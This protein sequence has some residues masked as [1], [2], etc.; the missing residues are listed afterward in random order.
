MIQ[1]SRLCQRQATRLPPPG[2]TGR[3]RSRWPPIDPCGLSIEPMPAVCGLLTITFR[4]NGHR[5]WF[6]AN[7]ETNY[8]STQGPTR[9]R[10]SA[11]VHERVRRAVSTGRRAAGDPVIVRS[12]TSKQAVG[13]VAVVADFEQ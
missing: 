7:V 12:R 1:V 13:D 3:L 11:G 6:P 10:P 9:T 5:M 8:S 4:T 2:L